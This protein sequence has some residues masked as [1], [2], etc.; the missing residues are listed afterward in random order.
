M[1]KL[2]LGKQRTVMGAYSPNYKEGDFGTNTNFMPG[3]NPNRYVGD[4]QAKLPG[5][6]NALRDTWGTGSG[7]KS[8]P[9]VSGDTGGDFSA[10]LPKV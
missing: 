9:Q 1:S 8:N 3:P 2:R 6:K 10:R 5:K 7:R 4:P